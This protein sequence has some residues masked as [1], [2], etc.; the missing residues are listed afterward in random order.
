MTT[1]REQIENVIYGLPASD[2]CSGCNKPFLC[3]IVDAILPVV[4]THAEAEVEKFAEEAKEVASV[5]YKNQ[6]NL[7][8]LAV[9]KDAIDDLLAAR[10]QGKGEK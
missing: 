8:V 4:T 10:K 9:T 5:A 3:D 2:S 6:N 7:Y 1:L